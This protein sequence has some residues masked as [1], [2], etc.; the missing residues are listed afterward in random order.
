MRTE[1]EL[2]AGMMRRDPGIFEEFVR[3]YQQ[4]VYF[5]ALRMMGERDEALDVA[6]EVFLKIWRFAARMKAESQLERWVYRITVNACID[7]LRERRR[8]DPPS[9]QSNVILLSLL[10]TGITPYEYAQQAQELLRIKQALGQLTERQRAVFVLRH[11][12]NQ[13]IN[14]IAD[15]LS[16]SVGAVKAT[17]HQTLMKLR[18][19]LSRH[20]NAGADI[21]SRADEVGSV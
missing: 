7:R 8:F 1:A 12:Q 14:E 2:I 18:G 17:L 4:R 19:L 10:E 11:F 15:I 13:K 3:R 6:Q 5:T 20:L 16:I 9:P 21:E